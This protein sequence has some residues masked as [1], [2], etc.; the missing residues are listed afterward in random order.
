MANASRPATDPA[1]SPRYRR[2]R[3]SMMKERIESC[4]EPCAAQPKSGNARK[5]KSTPGIDSDQ[6]LWTWSTPGREFIPS[7][8]TF[9]EST[10]EDDSPVL[11]KFEEV[12]DDSNEDSLIAMLDGDEFE[13]EPTEAVP[14]NVSPGITD[15]LHFFGVNGIDDQ[16]MEYEEGERFF[17]LEK[18][19]KPMARGNNRRNRELLRFEA[20]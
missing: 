8:G 12:S 16:E 11:A 19:V 4:F 1:T 14:K 13:D 3:A 10:D 9:L 15:Q 18:I 5:L 17:N 6:V 7:T 20:Q 2:S